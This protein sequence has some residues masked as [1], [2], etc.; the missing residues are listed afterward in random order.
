[1]GS[2]GEPT[3]GCVTD[4]RWCGSVAAQGT[5]GLGVGV[6]ADLA[7]HD[8][9]RAAFD[10]SSRGPD[11]FE[12]PQAVS[13]QG[14]AIF[15]SAVLWDAA[16][17]DSYE[18]T[19]HSTGRLGEEDEFLQG[20]EWSI[21]GG[22]GMVGQGVGL[23][24]DGTLLDGGGSDRIVAMARPAPDAALPNQAAPEGQGGHAG[25]I[26]QGYAEALVHDHGNGAIIAGIGD[27]EYTVDLEARL[28][29]FI[30]SQAS[31]RNP[32]ATATI[33]DAGG[34]DTYTLSAT[35]DVEFET[36][37]DCTKAVA[38]LDV[39]AEPF[40]THY[41]LARP[42][43]F[44]QGGPQ[45]SLRDR[46]G[47]DVYRASARSD[48]AVSAVNTRPGGL[49][50]ASVL[51]V[52]ETVLQ[53]QGMLPG[54]LQ[55]DGGDD[56]Y[57]LEAL[58]YADATARATPGTG[59]IADEQSYVVPGTV[60]AAGQGQGAAAGEGS[61]DDRGGEDVYE[62]RFDAEGTASPG[63]AGRE[64]DGI[65]SV[66]AQGSDGLLS[67][68]DQGQPDAFHAD[69]TGV[70]ETCVG[71]YGEGPGWVSGPTLR[72]GTCS[73]S[74][75]ET[76]ATSTLPPG[77]DTNLSVLT[78]EPAGDQAWPAYEVAVKLTDLSGEPLPGRRITVLP[79][80]AVTSPDPLVNAL[81]EWLN[82]T[83]NTQNLVTDDQG[84]ARGFVPIRQLL[85]E[86]GSCSGTFIVESDHRIHAMYFGEAGAYRPSRGTS[87]V[88]SDP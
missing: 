83:G 58:R 86:A 14:A 29:A 28:S 49:A 20:Q 41:G 70:F 21:P 15:G 26:V 81:Y 16:G 66:F 68:A 4:T 55:D 50:R 82:V 54:R 72:N 62:A 88:M 37:C 85:C 8:I 17:N 59:G 40:T 31:S 3:G 9:Y 53:A 51:G 79:E 60:Y 64:G 19:V 10:R 33:D 32:G 22:S 39:I 74:W 2:L 80:W 61:L 71:R 65:F 44:G 6:L 11:G 75:G 46:G 7:G 57:V 77:S 67:D 76:I 35:T 23:V 47:N 73:P 78:V 87:Q 34:N 24:G 27:T 30:Q 5:G 1:M 69:S 45:G 36:R 38:T 48:V 52:G 56:R 12:A 25:A 63:G 43:V 18:M 42:Q 13:A 84:I